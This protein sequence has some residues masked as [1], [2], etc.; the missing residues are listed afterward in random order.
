MAAPGLPFLVLA[1]CRTER[2]LASADG[3]FPRI[4]TALPGR[5]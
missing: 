3:P 5:L 2:T 1:G 4:R